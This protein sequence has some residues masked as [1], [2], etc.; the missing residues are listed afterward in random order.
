[1]RFTTKNEA[2]KATFISELRANGI[3]FE[4]KERLGYETFIGYMIEGTLEEIRAQIETLSGE[5]KEVILRGFQSFKEQ[6]IH[7][8]EHLKEGDTFEHLLN[9]GYWMGDIIDQLMRN[10]ALDIRENKVKLKDGIDVTKLKFQFRFPYDLAKQLDAVEKIAKQ[11]AF[12]DLVSE[13]EIEIKE[14]RIE[15]INQALQIAAKYFPEKDVMN[16]YFALIGKSIVANEILKAL[17]NEKV[18]VDVIIEK[19]LRAFPF[20]IPTEKGV[21]VIN[22]TEKSLYSILR[23]LEKSGYIGIKGNKVKKLREL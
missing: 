15:R 16:V 7:A 6:L 8:L 4:V 18:P 17:G 9:E 22:A 2:L 10:S 1:M 21:M 20:E 23:E 14:L 5:E 12:I 13:W 19:F 11:F 3:K